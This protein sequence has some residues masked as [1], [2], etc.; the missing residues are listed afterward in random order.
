VS[1]QADAQYLSPMERWEREDLRQSQWN[2]IASYTVLPKT[3]DHVSG[4]NMDGQEDNWSI[5]GN[6]QSEK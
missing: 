2:N 1:G 3:M 4:Q 5:T 6:A